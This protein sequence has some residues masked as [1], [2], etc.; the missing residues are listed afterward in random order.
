MFFRPLPDKQLLQFC[1]I[2][3]RGW[4]FKQF[5]KKKEEAL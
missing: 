5:L 1:N 4:G 3:E 2:K